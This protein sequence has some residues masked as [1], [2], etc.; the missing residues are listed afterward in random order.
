MHYDRAGCD[1]LAVLS[2]I[3]LNMEMCTILPGRIVRDV[4]TSAAYVRM[5]SMSAMYLI[6]ARRP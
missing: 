6:D 1:G 2:K 4:S 3:A 5:I